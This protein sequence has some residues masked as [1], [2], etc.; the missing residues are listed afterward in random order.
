MTISHFRFDVNGFI[1][2]SAA[3]AATFMINDTEETIADLERVLNCL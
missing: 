1:E 2:S 3:L